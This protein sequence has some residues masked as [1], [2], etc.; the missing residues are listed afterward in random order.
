MMEW[1]I[2]DTW[3]ESL[4]KGRPERPL[5][6]RDYIWA[7]ELGGA[8]IDRFMKMSGVVPSNPPNP[9]SLRKFEAGNIWESIIKFV[10]IR[11]GIL[12]QSQEWVEFKYPDSLRVTGKLDFI[13]GGKPDFSLTETIMEKEFAWLPEFIGRATLNIVDKLKEI[14]KDLKS[15]ILEVKSCSSFMFDGYE[16]SGI[17]DPKHSLQLFHY[18]KAKKMDEGH[19]I[20]I[21]KDDARLLELEIQNPSDLEHE[22]YRDI[23]DMTE[24]FK[25]GTNPLPE[26]PIVWKDNFKKFSANWKIAYSNY[27]KNIYGFENQFAFENTYKPVV[28]AWNRVLTRLK[29]GDKMTDSNKKYLEEITKAGFDVEKLKKQITEDEKEVEA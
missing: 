19:I 28:S 5:V 20:Y 27:I 18:L 3:N 11:A 17:A 15:I 29:K 23:E 9:R 25:T 26:N 7:T 22:Y 6:P 24:Y 4:E 12:Q 16:K 10:L 14:Q 1:R 2:Y 13:A 21:C 8:Y